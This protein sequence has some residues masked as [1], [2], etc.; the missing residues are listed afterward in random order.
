MF[1]YLKMESIKTIR[2]VN[3]L[4]FPLIVLGTA[5]CSQNANK[6]KKE[7]LLKTFAY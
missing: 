5:A 3:D 1:A 2:F 4:C 7:A 6:A